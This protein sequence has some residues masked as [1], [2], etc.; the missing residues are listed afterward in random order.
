MT[1]NRLGEEAW[2]LP[3]SG[4]SAA[5]VEIVP[6]MSRTQYFIY[7]WTPRETILVVSSKPTQ[8]VNLDTSSNRSHQPVIGNCRYIISTCVQAY[9]FITMS[10][11]QFGFKRSSNHSPPPSSS[12]AQES[13]SYFI[14]A[15]EDSG[16]GRVEYDNVSAS[17]PQL[18]NPTPAAKKGKT[19]GRY[20]HYS[21]EDRASIGRYALENGNEKARQYFLVKFPNL[22]ESTI[23][24]FKKA[25]REKMDCQQKQL[26]SEPITKIMAQPRG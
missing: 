23:R 21:A 12:G 14:P 4:Y 22:K 6:F 26:H 18:A 16:L 17:V 24:N 2:E 10:L 19:R 5:I 1:S 8:E 15:L 9:V 20:T 11:F 13:V 7:Q 25:Y 3:C